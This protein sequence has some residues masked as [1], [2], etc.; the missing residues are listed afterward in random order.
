MA[1]DVKFKGILKRTPDGFYYINIPNDII[2]GF[3]SATG[4]KV[5][6]PPYFSRK[7]GK[8]G[9]HIS[10]IGSSESEDSDIKEVGK[11]FE[12]TITGAKHLKPEG[13]DEMKQVFFIVVKSPALEKLRKK[14]K[15]PAKQHGH[16]FH[17]TFAVQSR[18][19]IHRLSALYE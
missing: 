4:K 6:R 3:R 12:Y 15:L 9:A 7:Y 16:E 2:D 11:E 8:V 18:E 14:Y 5:K 17:I 1:D 13:W 10:V 19:S